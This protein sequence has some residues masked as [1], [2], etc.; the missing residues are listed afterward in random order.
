MNSQTMKAHN[1]KKT[2]ELVIQRKWAGQWIS[3]ERR[4][5]SNRNRLN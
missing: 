1:R 5:R 2:R 3:K 4:V